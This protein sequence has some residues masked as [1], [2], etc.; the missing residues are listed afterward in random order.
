MSKVQE[1]GQL[2]ERW[3]TSTD[4]IAIRAARLIAKSPGGIEAASDLLA[5]GFAAG[6]VSGVKHEINNEA[7]DVLADFQG[8]KQ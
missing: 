3:L 8:T 4:P 7:R 6:Y 5:A 2:F 1:I